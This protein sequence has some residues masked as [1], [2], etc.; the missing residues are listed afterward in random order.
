MGVKLSMKTA[1]RD[2]SDS[3]SERP[4]LVPEDALSFMVSYHGDDWVN[5]LIT[6]A[7]A[8]APLISTSTKLPPFQID[9]GRQPYPLTHNDLSNVQTIIPAADYA[10]NLVDDRKHAEKFK[11]QAG[12]AETVL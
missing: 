8:H 2:Q 6:I 5:H 3:Q 10:Q 1:H 11:C 7:Y 9:T 12:T 4:N